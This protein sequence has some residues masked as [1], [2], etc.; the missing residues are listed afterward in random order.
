MPAVPRPP[1]RS[2]A[3]AA[4]L[5]VGV[6]AAVLGAALLYAWHVDRQ[7]ER[8]RAGREPG[9]IQ[10]RVPVQYG[11]GEESPAATVRDARAGARETG[12]VPARERAERLASHGEFAQA[13]R[14]LEGVADGAGLRAEILVLVEA[15]CEEAERLA[16]ADPV[17]GMELMED[18]AGRVPDAE[19][20]RLRA[21]REELVAGVARE[22]AAARLA[23]ADRLLE[24]GKLE[25]GILALIAAAR[26]LPGEAKE[27]ALDRAARWVRHARYEGAIPAAELA[28]M[29]GESL[30]RVERAV[31]SCLA[32]DDAAAFEKALADLLRLP[33][34]TPDFVRAVL[35]RGGTPLD[36]PT[37]DRIVNHAIAGGALRSCG[38]SV[39]ETGLPT[40]PRPLL[41]LLMPSAAPP[42]AARGIA[43]SWRHALGGDLIVAVA[44]PDDDA[45]WGPNRAGEAHVPGL[46]RALR[47]QWLVDPDRVVLS[48]ISAGAHGAWFQ[49][50]RHGD[51]FS[52]VVGIAGT[53]YA[54]LYGTHWLDWI[55]NLRLFP[56]RALVGGKDTV[57]PPSHARTFGRIA[58]EC[59]ARVEVIED[60][61]A[62]HEGASPEAEKKVLAEALALRRDPWPKSATWS[63]D[64]LE[65]GRCAWI[66]IAAFEAGAK[67]MTVNFVDDLGATVEKRRILRECA[68]VD[69][70]VSGQAIRLR[71]VRVGRL[72]LHLGPGLVDLRQEVTVTVNGSEAFR[73]AA[74]PG[75]ETMIREARS[76]GRRD[77]VTD[78]V[79]EIDVK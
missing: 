42:E 49:A 62:G 70:E 27:A 4:L 60:P 8:A 40:R 54:P 53:P 41:V 20:A 11:A 18:L 22:A 34:A 59:G 48:G 13:L 37:G 21:R 10:T 72:R 68:R 43:R 64:S 58:A 23:E 38:V 35:L 55:S 67:E 73:G 32:A 31:E 17:R 52:S 69:A 47:R 2:N 3:H 9:V 79:L 65:S 25:D 66:E 5:A 12:V 14:E 29:P 57:F 46:L 45:G 51:L 77:R 63:T 16:E 44:N 50:M 33:A 56:S 19:S 30:D 74:R 76:G 39:P 15:A 26:I 28:T 1:D 24:A 7:N 71:T 78:A 61:A 75:V 36:A 6:G